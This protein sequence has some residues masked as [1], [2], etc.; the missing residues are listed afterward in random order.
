MAT[1][2]S[3]RHLKPSKQLK[4]KRDVN[5]E[6]QILAQDK[7]NGFEKKLGSLVKFAFVEVCKEICSKDLVVKHLQAHK[8]LT[9]K[10]F[11]YIYK[12]ASRLKT[13]TT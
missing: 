4:N 3:K 8:E 2:L 12:V 6:V 7:L 11:N 9:G 13:K 5:N 1:I 10:M